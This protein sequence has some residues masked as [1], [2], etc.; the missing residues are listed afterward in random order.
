MT[1]RHQDLLGKLCSCLDFPYSYSSRSCPYTKAAIP[2]V[3]M[4]LATWEKLREILRNKPLLEQYLG[5]EY[6]WLLIEEGCTW[7]S[8][9]HKGKEVEIY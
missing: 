1:L 3:T 2:A 9:E 4:P 6:Q 8:V 7:Y 5:D